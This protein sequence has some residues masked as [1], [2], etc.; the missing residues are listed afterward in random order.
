MPPRR[1]QFPQLP[2]IVEGSSIGKR[3]AYTT[4]TTKDERE[5]RKVKIQEQNKLEQYKESKKKETK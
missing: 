1:K 2:A 5:K 4:G 3:E